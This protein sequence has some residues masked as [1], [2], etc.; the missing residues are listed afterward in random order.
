MLVLL[1]PSTALSAIRPAHKPPRLVEIQANA[2]EPGDGSGKGEAAVAST[3]SQYLVAWLDAPGSPS[4]LQVARVGMDGEVLDPG[5]V[6]LLDEHANRA[7]LVVAANDEQYLIA[8]TDD[9]GDGTRDLLGIVV[10]TQAAPSD[11]EPVTFA[12]DVTGPYPLAE[13]RTDPTAT[14]PARPKSAEAPPPRGDQDE[15]TKIPRQNRHRSDDKRN[16]R[17]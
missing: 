16:P 4:R 2:F 14:P 13:D 8:W 17:D 9:A 10:D 12:K 11:P 1:P 3:L 7:D 5:G 6:V 15:P